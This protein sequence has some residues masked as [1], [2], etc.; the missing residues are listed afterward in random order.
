M[1]ADSSIRLLPG[2]DRDDGA[3]MIYSGPAL[4]LFIN[5][6]TI[7]FMMRKDGI[8]VHIIP[9]VIWENTLKNV[10]MYSFYKAFL[11]SCV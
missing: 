4:T 5:I 2:K 7:R 8:P 10:H 11:F 6:I 3:N 1:S 9:P